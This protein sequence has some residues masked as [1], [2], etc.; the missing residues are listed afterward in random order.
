MSLIPY[1]YPGLIK[2]D[3]N[4]T[5]IEHSAFF[6]RTAGNV[7][8][9]RTPSTTGNRQKWT[10]STWLKIGQFSV[11]RGLFGA[12]AS[13][14]NYDGIYFSD[15]NKLVIGRRVAN[16]WSFVTQTK[17]TFKDIAK[18]YHLC[19]VID[20]TQTIA[21]DRLKVYVN[22]EI[23]ELEKISSH[24]QYPVLNQDGFIGNT[25]EHR[26][27][28]TNM[29]TTGIYYFDGILSDVYFTSGQTLGPETF[30]EYRNQVWVPKI[31]TGSFINSGVDFRLKFDN[32]LSLGQ[33]SS[34]HG[35]H[36]TTNGTV[37]FCKDT[38]TRNFPVVQSNGYSQ[39]GIV[40]VGNLFVRSASYTYG[41]VTTIQ[42]P[43]TGK[44]YFEVIQTQVSSSATRFGVV[45]P[46]SDEVNRGNYFLGRD[47]SVDSDCVGMTIT[48]GEI[49]QKF[50]N[51]WLVLQTVSTLNNVGSHYGVGIDLDNESI[52]FFE[53][54]VAIGNAVSI[55]GRSTYDWVFFVSGHPN[56]KFLA[57]F[58]QGDIL[59]YTPYL[60]TGY[61]YL[62]TETLPTP[63]ISSGKLGFEA[64]SYIGD[65]T[66]ANSISGMEF[67]PDMVWVKDIDSAYS[68]R[69]VDK[70]RGDAI[71]SQPNSSAV[72]LASGGTIVS[73]DNQGFTVGYNVSDPN[74]TNQLNKKHISYSFRRGAQYGFDIVGYTGNGANRTIAHNLSKAPELMLIKR[75]N[76][77]TADWAVYSR[78]MT[79]AAYA[80][81][82]NLTNQ[83]GTYATMFNSTYPTASVFT[84][85]THASVNASGSN[86]IAYL[87]RSIPDFSKCFVYTGNGSATN[88]PLVHVGFRPA[89]VMIK[90]LTAV[91]NWQVQDSTINPINPATTGIRVDTTDSL[92]SVNF[93]LDMYSN[94][95]KIL[96]SAA[97]RNTNGTKYI[98]IAFAHSP[99]KYGNA[100]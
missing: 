58:G 14:N 67:S 69:I 51:S 68:H 54:G 91:G 24:N 41:Y 84:V 20:T 50:G 85:G 42:L 11:V 79:S 48:N 25:I 87:F 22:G 74:G 46:H 31:F 60:P 43:N 36:M 5:K 38:P 13:N 33:D 59:G 100:V 21:S 47:T 45:T 55:T 44:Y 2:S 95:F 39:Y 77:T 88:G 7:Y 86:Y 29:S 8:F 12:F 49:W 32:E 99:F 52:Q 82:W 9:S 57:N 15:A 70:V 78:Y 18:H 23:C 10:F 26:L 89:F 65:G 94:G 6:N 81:F 62:N 92:V 37:Y 3:I 35:N 61:Q 28:C 83:Q 76:T 64:I 27:G 97:G 66:Q 72:E 90:S 19:I 16:T 80:L 4:D 40:E 73:L 63:D 75:R 71:F 98:G 56:N 30:G 34:G 93:E 1:I 96:S 53:N 17:R